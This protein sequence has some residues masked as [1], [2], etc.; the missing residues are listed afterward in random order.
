[1]RSKTILSA[2]AFI[3]TFVFSAF[4]ASLF[5]PETVQPNYVYSD[6]NSRSTSCFKKR[7]QSQNAVE[8]SSLLRQDIN[9]GRKRDRNLIRIDVTAN[10]PFG[11]DNYDEYAAIIE[12]YSGES[13][14]LETDELPSDFD[15]AWNAHMKAWRDYTEFL[16]EMKD[17]SN[18]DVSIEKL[19]RIDAKYGKEI[20]DTWYRVLRIARSYDAEIY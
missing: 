1:M 14:S 19:K 2:A 18:T 4:L 20:N 11:E 9:N 10:T 13:K 8:I 17:P 3:A 6:Y 15:Q 5:L 7:F 12:Q 16:N